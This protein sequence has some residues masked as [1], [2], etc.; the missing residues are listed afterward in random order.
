MYSWQCALNEQL[1]SNDQFANVWSRYANVE[2]QFANAYMPVTS[3]PN[4]QNTFLFGSAVDKRTRNKLY[5]ALSFGYTHLAVFFGSAVDKRTRNNWNACKGKS[6]PVFCSLAALANWHYSLANRLHMLANWLVGKMIGYRTKFMRP[7]F[8]QNRRQNF[9][10]VA[11]KNII[12]FQNTDS[13]F[14]QIK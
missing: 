10:T 13:R 1:V 12:F 11:L 14:S 3:G 4:V 9:W 5:M 2:C 7:W 8:S 6:G